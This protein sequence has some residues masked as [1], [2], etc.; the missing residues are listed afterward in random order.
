MGDVKSFV[1]SVGKIPKKV[2]KGVNKNV[3]GTFDKVTGTNISGT[4]KSHDGIFKKGGSI[5]GDA[6]A[7]NN[8]LN[9]LGRLFAGKPIIGKDVKSIFNI[10][11]DISRLPGQISTNINREKQGFLN[12]YNKFRTQAENVVNNFSKDGRLPNSVGNFFNNYRPDLQ[13]IY[14]DKMPGIGKTRTSPIPKPTDPSSYV[15]KPGKGRVAPS[16]NP[17]PAPME[18]VPVS[19]AP[20]RLTNDDFIDRLKRR[21]RWL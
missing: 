4:N 14:R 16:A 2:V 20:P 15:P 8:N 3:T 17:F 21:N 18:P 12:K 6:L 10:P 19:E 13:N 7:I 1:N 11:R 5:I 9:P